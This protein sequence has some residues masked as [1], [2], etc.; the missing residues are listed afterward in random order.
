MKKATVLIIML[1]VLMGCSAQVKHVPINSDKE[2][3]DD[4]GIRY[5]RSSPYLIVYSNGK[6]GIVTEIKYLP[7]PTKKMSAQPNS[8]FATGL[9][10]TMNF[11]HGVLT[12]VKDELGGD[13][14]SP[15]ILK[16]VETM[17]PALLK[18]LNLAQDNVYTVPAPY[19]YKIVVTG[20]EVKFVGGQ[21]DTALKVTLLPQK[22]QE[23]EQEQEEPQ[24]Q[25]Q[26][27]SQQ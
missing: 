22:E 19:I 24:Q 23:Q 16:A 1:G 12:S 4:R 21:G 17:G 15:A 25:G 27:D 13:I 11:D 20:E 9:K 26:E 8:S 2:D 5:Y 3:A 10:T 14:I 7:D 18:A 6:G